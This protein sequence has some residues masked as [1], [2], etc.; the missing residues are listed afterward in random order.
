M[1]FDFFFFK[2]EKNNLE[3]I[4]KLFSPVFWKSSILRK[5]EQK[6]LKKGITG[7]LF[8]KYGYKNSML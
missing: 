6:H 7:H 5:Y 2:I 1:C 3:G 4:N 8:Q